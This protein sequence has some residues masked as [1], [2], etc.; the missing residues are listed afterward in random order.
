MPAAANKKAARGSGLLSRL[1]F[2]DAH[3]GCSS[4]A[5]AELV[6]RALG[7]VDDPLAVERPTIIDGHLDGFAGVLVR[8]PQLGAKRERSV[9]RGHG[10]FIED[11][12]GCRALSIK[13]RAVPGSTA[14]LGIGSGRKAQDGSGNGKSQ[15]SVLN[16]A[17]SLTSIAVSRRLTAGRGQNVDRF[18]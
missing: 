5:E 14:T 2:F 17:S 11:L 7:K 3:R 1:D 15:Q 6:C 4:V 18:A 13:A 12:P 16:Q 9:R 10:I 8:H